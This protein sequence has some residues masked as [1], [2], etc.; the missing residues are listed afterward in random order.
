M[1]YS[2]APIYLYMNSYIHFSRKK[3]FDING[4]IRELCIS[5]LDKR[6]LT[7][8]DLD[9]I[10]ISFPYCKLKNLDDYYIEIYSYYPINHK[11]MFYNLLEKGIII[12]IEEFV[13][14]LERS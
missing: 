1:K 14:L 4:E 12:S 5:F 13:N 2:I 10:Q 8:K 6:F 3:N 11:Q 9:E 7:T